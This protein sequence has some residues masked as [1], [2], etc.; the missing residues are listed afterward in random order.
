MAYG[1]GVH[2]NPEASA[3]GKYLVGA[4]TLIIALYLVAQV[5][6]LIATILLGGF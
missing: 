3:F 4:V 5:G 2:L 6:K 1:H